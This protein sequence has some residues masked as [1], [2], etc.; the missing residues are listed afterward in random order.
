MRWTL[1]RQHLDRLGTGWRQRLVARRAE[2][3][4]LEWRRHGAQ[5]R[6]EQHPLVLQSET[7]RFDVAGTAVSDKNATVRDSTSAKLLLGSS[8]SFVPSDI[9]N[10]APLIGR[11]RCAR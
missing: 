6:F 9:T 1:D 10:A 11:P 4:H 2:L 3:R 7:L 5:S 8:T